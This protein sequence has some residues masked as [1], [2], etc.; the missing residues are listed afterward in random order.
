MVTVSQAVE[1]LERW[2]FVL[3]P[4]SDTPQTRREQRR[5]ARISGRDAE[6]E[7]ARRK[8][9]RPG[10]QNPTTLITAAAVVAGLLLFV[11]L[12]VRPGS[13]TGTP[14]SSANPFGFVTP[15]VTIP[16]GLADGRSL[17]K[18]DA[19]VTLDV[20]AD[21]QCPFCGQLTRTVEPQIIA[22]LVAA[23]T[24]RL[25]AHDFVFLGAGHDPDES[26][27][28]AVAA[29]CADKQSRFWDY[30]EMLFWNQAAENSGGFSRDRLLGM[31]NR[32]GLDPGTFLTC[33]TDQSLVAAVA[34]ETAAGRASGVA[35]TPTAFI[36]GQAVVGLKDYATY[37]GLIATAAAAATPGPGG[38]PSNTASA[39]PSASAGGSAS[40]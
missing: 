29:R 14:A 28:A 3:D 22:N 24:V 2:S 31:A 27:D 25:V 40:P 36:N 18:A 37:A 13:S 19:P 32:L 11:V 4:R 30:Y 16:A 15:P 39:S 35:S 26:T 9:N 33:L 20:W 7:R 5:S 23:G 34:A 6:R 10:W 17:G 8:A 12:V 38:S 1:H 21:F